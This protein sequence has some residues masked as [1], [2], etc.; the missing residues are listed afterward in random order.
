MIDLIDLTLNFPL[1][2]A[3]LAM[4][5]FEKPLPPSKR[6]ERDLQCKGWLTK[7]VVK[8]DSKT[9]RLRFCPAKVLGSWNATGSDN[10]REL[11]GTLVPSIFKQVQHRLSAKQEGLIGAGDYRL[12]EVHI[13]NSFCLPHVDAE[14]F[15]SMAGMVISK[16]RLLE[17]IHP[18]V[19]FRLSPRSRTAEYLL[20]AK[21][22]ETLD[23][24]RKRVRSFVTE[25]PRDKRVWVLASFGHQL[26]YAAAGPRLEIRLRDQFFA[27]SEF[28]AG[29]A[30]GPT[31]AH[32]LYVAKLR[33]LQLPPAVRV[34]PDRLVAESR[35]KRPVLS[36]F[37]HWAAGEDLSRVTRATT[38]QRHRAA[39][40]AALDI[41]IAFPAANHFGY[42]CDI[43]VGAVLNADNLLPLN[44]DPDDWGC[45]DTVY[46]RAQTLRPPR[47]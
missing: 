29:R 10:L 46:Q 44:F 14:E 12:H 20:Y 39:I 38:L 25:L 30:W 11:V 26:N 3:A 2:Q 41:D 37:L 19:G 18:G 15:I 17:W 4:F 35:L 9:V 43:E 33:D 8:F 22:R 27:R 28:R 32:D 42:S 6:Y 31:T 16:Q 5:G 34:V 24:G 40:L 36:T 21:L 1:D 23:K 47:R 7:V 13:A 45:A